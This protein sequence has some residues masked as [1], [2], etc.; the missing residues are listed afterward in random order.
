MKSEKDVDSLVGFI[1]VLAVA[2]LLVLL[3]GV[4]TVV[5]PFV[6]LGVI[7]LT[8]FSW[9]FKAVISS[10]VQ[11]MIGI[12]VLFGLVYLGKLYLI[13]NKKNENKIL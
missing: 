11:W 3:L 12:V 2:S 9:L 6:A 10:L 8:A 13:R 7:S 1:F 5:A 4:K